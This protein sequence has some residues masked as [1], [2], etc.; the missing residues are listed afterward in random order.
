MSFPRDSFTRPCTLSWKLPSRQ[1]IFLAHRLT[2]HGSPRMVHDKLANKVYV[3]HVSSD[4]RQTKSSAFTC[5]LR[6]PRFQG[7]SSYHP[8]GRARRDPGWVWSRAT[9]TVENIGEG[10]SVFR[11]FFCPR[12]C[13]MRDPWKEVGTSHVWST[14]TVA[15]EWL[16]RK[17]RGL[18]GR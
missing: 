11:Q 18:N 4:T 15:F 12:G 14:F 8:L 5:V 6:Q 16:D 10:S 3:Y 17:L 2:A 7:L 13:K 1:F 9:L